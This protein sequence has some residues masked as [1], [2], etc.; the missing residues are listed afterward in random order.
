[1][2]RAELGHLPRPHSP[3]ESPPWCGPERSLPRC[4]RTGCCHRTRLHG[5]VGMGCPAPLGPEWSASGAAHCQARTLASAGPWHC[6]PWR[7]SWDNSP[8]TGNSSPGPRLCSPSGGLAGSGPSASAAQP[9]PARGEE[10]RVT[11]SGSFSHGSTQ[12]IFTD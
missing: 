4:S 8:G 9:S 6:L 2:G 11:V 1:M 10:G 3:Q 12:Q 5:P 7:A